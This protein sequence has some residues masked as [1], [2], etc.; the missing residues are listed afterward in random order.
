MPVWTAVHGSGGWNH[1]TKSRIQEKMTLRYQMTDHCGTKQ[2]PAQKLS[3]KPRT[4]QTMAIMSI[5]TR[6]NPQ[7]PQF[8]VGC[9]P[10][11]R[12]TNHVCPYQ[13]DPVEGGPA[14]FPQGPRHLQEGAAQ[15]LSGATPPCLGLPCHHRYRP[16]LGD[17]E[18]LG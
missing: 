13:E 9:V 12:E 4:Q 17:L 2:Y 16:R 6:Q 3:V 7:I 8:P 11:Q 1:V 18:R 14:A 15:L 5:Q 10:Q